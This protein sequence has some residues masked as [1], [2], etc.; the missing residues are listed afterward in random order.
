MIL[1]K[2]A[3][4]VPDESETVNLYEPSPVSVTEKTTWPVISD[5]SGTFPDMNGLVRLLATLLVTGEYRF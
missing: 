4:S 1:E 3:I 2:D 5:F